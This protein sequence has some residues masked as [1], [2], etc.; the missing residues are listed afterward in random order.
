VN[1]SIA[2]SIVLA[3]A[4]FLAACNAG[5]GDEGAMDNQY[6]GNNYN[7]NGNLNGN[8]MDNYERNRDDQLGYV[9]Y[10][11]DQVNTEGNYETKIDRE[12]M[13]DTITKMILS[14]EQFEDAATL[15]SD[16][17]VLVA[18]QKPADMDRNE[19][20]DMVKKTAASLVPRF[21]EIYVS[22]QEEAFDEIQSLN[23]SSVNDR[24]YDNVLEDIIKD[25][26]QAP[27]GDPMYNDETNSTKDPRDT[28]DK[29]M[30]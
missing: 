27:Q 17:E 3:S 15:V 28:K 6:N 12:A 21:Y 1:K 9:R 2:S 19:A 25:M 26:R 7:N 23:N 16:D 24:N 4:L 14:Y 11:K 20:A 22:D 5:G 13:S 18:Y 29:M 30:K 8:T 10:N